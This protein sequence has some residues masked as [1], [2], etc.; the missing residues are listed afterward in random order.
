MMA[1][2]I[3]ALP[4]HARVIFLGDRDQ[5]ASVEAGAV[6]GDICR[7]AQPGIYRCARRSSAASHR[8]FARTVCRQAADAMAAALRDS[9]CLLRKS[10][11]FGSDSGIGQ[12][13]AAVNAGGGRSAGPRGGV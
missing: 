5:L 10:Y 12:L 6:L 2:L 13:A 3:D 8:L 7:Y 4:A 11:R 1:R 9:L